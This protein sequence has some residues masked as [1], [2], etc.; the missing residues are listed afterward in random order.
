MLTTNYR[1]AE[2]A[3][4]GACQNSRSSVGPHPR[5]RSRGPCGFTF[6]FDARSASAEADG[7]EGTFSG[8]FLRDGLFS[9]V[10]TCLQV[11]GNMTTIGGVITSG[12]PQ[13]S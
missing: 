10:V 7:V 12:R 3:A 9:G 4:V 2:L 13:R 5:D 1:I 6:S 8:S 11:N